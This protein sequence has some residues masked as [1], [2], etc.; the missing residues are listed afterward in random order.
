MNEHTGAFRSVEEALAAASPRFPRP[1]LTTSRARLLAHA[2]GLPHPP[3]TDL[4]APPESLTESH[5]APE[6]LDADE[7]AHRLDALCA[8]V[9]LSASAGSSLAAFAEYAAADPGG[10]LVFAC[11]LHLAGDGEGA[12]FW[13]RLAAGA[14]QDV[15]AHCLFLDHSRRG[16]YH[17][18]TLWARRLADPGALRALCVD[19]PLP[20]PRLR[21]ALTRIGRLTDR[22]D[23]E[24][25]GPVPLASPALAKEVFTLA[26]RRDEPA[27]G[28]WMVPHPTT[29]HRPDARDTGPD[30]RDGG[31]GEAR[32][33]KPSVG[34]HAAEKRP[35]PD[36]KTTA[37]TSDGAAKARTPDGK[38]TA[39][40]PGQEATAP[41][42]SG[43]AKAPT[44]GREATAPAP[45][46]KAVPP[47]PA[48]SARPTETT[49]PLGRLDTTRPVTPLETARPTLLT[50]PMETPRPAASTVFSGSPLRHTT[51][52][53]LA[54]RMPDAPHAPDRWTEAM[55]VL[56]VLH[57]VRGARRPLAPAEIASSAGLA[58]VDLT[59]LLRWLR[60]H[61][62]LSRL[63]DG[64]YGVGPLFS[65]APAGDP[66][67]RHDTLTRLLDELR[68]TTGAAVYLSRY[69][70]GEIDIQHCSDSPA[71]PAI[72]Q[73]VDLR[74][75]A[76][77]SANGKSLMAQLDFESRMD[78]LARHRPY[79]LTERTI[80]DPAALFR[81]LDGHGPHASQFDVL[82]YSRREVCVAVPVALGE[83]PACVALSLPSDRLPRLVDAARILS[84]QSALILLT[85]LAVLPAEP[86]PA[87]GETAK[88]ASSAG[89]PRGGTA[90][91]H[92][93]PGLLLPTGSPGLPPAG[94]TGFLTGTR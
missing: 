33:A 38:A 46:G 94:W 12:T 7:A 77:A 41:A 58:G 11:V 61:L 30:G 66:V 5:D 76:H 26:L 86:A 87:P 72:T 65:P 23:H 56:D 92:A 88:D 13:W 31:P 49:R 34:L 45:D 50:R 24:D 36:G 67:L 32:R 90:S 57:A 54:Q 9:V 43:K 4:A 60:G 75:A 17:D 89:P 21:Q 59:Q 18:A 64:S 29:A 47:A 3:A 83:Q 28:H 16:E 20:P 62:L 8:T 71:A 10:A 6:P 27:P 2:T 85:L 39:P 52:T 44:P 25:H 70:D 19:A 82:E 81:A 68:D 63:T 15:A 35:M 48:G 84:G 14:E 42:P 53:A 80:T 93:V 78:H 40:T 22:H 91:R 74:E 37:R 69:T 51:L 79:A 73:W 1:D 55:R